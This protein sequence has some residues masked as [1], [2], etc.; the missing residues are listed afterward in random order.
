MTKIQEII[1]GSDVPTKL[2]DHIIGKCDDSVVRTGDWEY[3]KKIVTEQ[4]TK[5]LQTLA[6]EAEEEFKLRLKK[7]DIIE[8]IDHEISASQIEAEELD[9]LL[10]LIK[11]YRRTRVS[12]EPKKNW[13]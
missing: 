4:L 6:D 1:E 5:G 10:T 2:T 3:I 9:E 13:F 7:R 11:D 12:Q 8:L